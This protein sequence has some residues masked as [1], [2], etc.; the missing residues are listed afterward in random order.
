MLLKRTSLL[1]VLCL[2]GIS[3]S[4]L[5]Q[6]VAAAKSRVPVTLVI[7]DQTVETGASIIKRFAGSEPKDVILLRS[8]ASSADLSE[9]IRGLLLTR[10]VSGDLPTATG[11]FRIRAKQSTSVPRKDFPWAARVLRD[12]TNASSRDLAGIGRVRAVEV[13]LP[14]QKPLNR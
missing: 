11:S 6:R 2:F 7:S 10:Q 1:S 9:A 3:T 8:G 12:L 4:I 13:W 14:A 5:A